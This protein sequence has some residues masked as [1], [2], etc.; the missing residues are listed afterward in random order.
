MPNIVDNVL[1]YQFIKRFTKPYEDW[2][3]FK[4]G[5]IDSSGNVIKKRKDLTP[6]E[7]KVFG[8]YDRLILNLRKLLAKLPGGTSRLGVWAATALLLKEGDTLDSDNVDILQE[9]LDIEMTKV[10]GIKLS[11]GFRVFE[12]AGAV[13]GNAVGGGH[14]AGTK[15]AGDDPPVRKKDWD[16]Y[17]RKNK[18]FSTMPF[19]RRKG[20]NNG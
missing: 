3:A 20:A 2:P 4:A 7:D 14:I 8:N 16:K 15:E 17:K 1:T 9:K 12:D 5:I 19:A 10:E 11:E 13:P 6:E 18:K